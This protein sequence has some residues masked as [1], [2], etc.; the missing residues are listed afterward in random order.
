MR[1]T[2]QDY[3]DKY[4]IESGTRRY[5][6]VL[7]LLESRRKTY[8]TQPYVRFTR[9]WFIWKY[10]DDG[11]FRFNEHVRKSRQSEENMIH[12]WG[13]E[14]GKQKW[15]E[16]VA[17]KNT[18]ALVRELRGE[19]GVED[20]AAKRKEG[21]NNYWNK[22]SDDEKT[23]ATAS[24]VQKA[25]ETKKQR[26]GD[27]T[28]LELYL[29][30]YG[31]DGHIKYAEHLQKIFKSIGHSAEAEKL[32]KTIINDNSWLLNYT[33]Y[34]RDVND[35]TK[36]EWFLSNKTGVWFYDLCVKEAKAILEYDG[37]RW[38]PTLSQSTEHGQDLM[39]IIGISYAEK[40][41]KDQLKI[42][43]ANDAGF[44]VFVI[45]SDFTE[46]DK[47]AIIQ[48]YL[49][50]IKGIINNELHTHSEKIC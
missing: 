29:E 26:Y 32:I 25:K 31:E 17:K 45:R 20:M 34:Y 33:I 3:I 37:S 10:P 40:Y 49:T 38:H 46:Y 30:K 24:R 42:K 22:L 11:I 35:K 47:A 1:M 8:D 23:A 7:K 13:T 36:A 2:L 43:V 6:G 12:R 15:Q 28:K 21:I 14:L 48:D 18:I 9:A 4:G 16:T 41:K 39:A 50:Y 5:N 19:A 44:K 27:K